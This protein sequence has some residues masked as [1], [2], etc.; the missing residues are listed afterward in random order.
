M[1]NKRKTRANV[2]AIVFIYLENV[3]KRMQIA[4]QTQSVEI[5]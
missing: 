4:S 3:A 1:K 2:R 5:N